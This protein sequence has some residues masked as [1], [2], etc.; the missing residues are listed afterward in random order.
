MVVPGEGESLYDLAA[1]TALE[2]VEGNGWL[3]KLDESYT[4][5]SDVTSGKSWRAV[6]GKPLWAK[7]DFL[8][9]RSGEELHLYTLMGR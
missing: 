1:G 4:K 9:T 7:G 3:A 8:L 2:T 6:V 5:L